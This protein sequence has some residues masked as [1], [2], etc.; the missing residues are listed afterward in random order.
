L[1]IISEGAPVP[2]LSALTLSAN[3]DLADARARREDLRATARLA[4]LT[5]RRAH[6]YLARRWPQMAPADRAVVAR[7]LAEG[8]P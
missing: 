5:L 4:P 1:N 7:W 8:C 2:I 3:E 6:D